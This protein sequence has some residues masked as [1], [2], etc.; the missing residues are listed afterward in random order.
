MSLC[1][2]LSEIWVAGCCLVRGPPILA[3]DQV[4]GNGLAN[5]G[6]QVRADRPDAGRSQL[7]SLLGRCSGLLHNDVKIFSGDRHEHHVTCL[8]SPNGGQTRTH[9][10]RTSC[11]RTLAAWQSCRT[12]Q[13]ASH[14]RWEPIFASRRTWRNWRRSR[15][16]SET[17]MATRSTCRTR[18]STAFSP[19]RLPRPPGWPRPVAE[20]W[21]TSRSTTAPTPEP[22]PLSATSA[23]PA[24]WAWW[25]A[26]SSI[27]L[28][29][30]RGSVLASWRRHGPRRSARAGFPSS[31]LQRPPRLP[32][33]ISGWQEIGRCKFKAPG[34]AI[35]EE[36]VFA[37][38]P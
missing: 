37:A 29:A 19:V 30:A 28:P 17:S 9:L 34:Q 35:V 7:T 13:R 1:S 18:T 15:P 3:S 5:C 4:F 22:W 6:R 11:L 2:A 26:C 32:S 8:D 23:S 14:R 36:I 24:T 20:S 38:Q 25:P 16:V 31:T 12:R 10:S 21:V 33:R 27:R